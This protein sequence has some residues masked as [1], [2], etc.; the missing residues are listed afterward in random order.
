M[1]RGKSAF[2]VGNDF[3]LPVMFEQLDPDYIDEVK[4]DPSMSPLQFAREY[5]S[6]WTGSS[7]NSL[8]QLKDL[9]KCRVLTKAEFSAVKKGDHKYVISVDVARSER[10]KSATTAIAIFK[11]S[12]RGNG[13]YYKQLVNLHTYK[14]NMH[15]EDQSIYIKDLVE[16]YGASMV[17]VDGNGLGR[18]LIDYLVK[19]DKYRSYSVV[20]DDSYDKYKLPNSL[21]LI[22]NVMSNTKQTNSSDIHNNFMAVISN[23]NL[24]LLIS[25]SIM[26]EK[27][28][29]RTQE[30]K[31]E[32]L[33]KLAEELAPHIETG[34][35]VDEVMNL[36]YVAEGN[37]TKVK[38]VSR[39]MD[40][41]RYSAVSYGLWYIYLEEEKNQ[42]RKK[43][44]FNARGMMAVKK[45]K[46]KVFS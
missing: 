3:T 45:A 31:M 16:K 35:F 33:E 6:V 8:V 22:F 13:T 4:N 18:G 23:H 10:K 25:D 14:G 36:I 1:A 21:P 32:K 2:V 27:I 11:I 15:F 40:K 20:N 44:T 37:R 7:E 42:Q 46:N 29:G 38:Q 17:C 43:Q 39:N 12:P 24:K 30:D 26:K 28:K 41:D 5:V 19:E 34:Y 9:E